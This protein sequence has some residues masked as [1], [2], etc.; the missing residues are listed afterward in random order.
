[1]SITGYTSTLTTSLRWSQS[2]TDDLSVTT[3][4]QSLSHTATKTL[5]T[6][7]GNA[8]LVWHDTLSAASTLNP[9]ALPRNVF[10]IGGTFVFTSLKTV[11]IKNAQATGNVTVTVPSCGISS[12]VTLH[13]GAIL[14]LDSPAGWAV[15]GSIVITAA[16]AVEVVLVGVG[17][18]TP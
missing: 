14:L 18:V 6:A 15:S 16:T 11:R 5:G 7:D 4:S 12:P 13:P 8:N 3:D 9:A 2:E 17:T 1:M 10:G